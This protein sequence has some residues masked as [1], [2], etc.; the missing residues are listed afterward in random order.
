LIE[1][2]I[3]ESQLTSDPVKNQ[4]M[5]DTQIVEPLVNGING[6]SCLTAYNFASVQ[7]SDATAP[8]GA[9]SLLFS[10][11]SLELPRLIR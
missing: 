3:W 2:P 8:R 11:E 10:D 1:T 6:N 7:G 5:M 4:V 9:Y